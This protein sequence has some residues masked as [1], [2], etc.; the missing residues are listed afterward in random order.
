MNIYP[1]REA[2]GALI[3][4]LPLLLFSSCCLIR[5]W[6]LSTHFGC[7]TAAVTGSLTGGRLTHGLKGGR[8]LRCDRGACCRWGDPLP[9]FWCHR[10]RGSN[11]RS[12]GDTGNRTEGAWGR[13]LVVQVEERLETEQETERSGGEVKVV[14]GLDLEKKAVGGR[15]GRMRVWWW[16]GCGVWGGASGDRLEKA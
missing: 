2:P 1:G 10:S 9:A 12:W 13:D 6:I 3:P 15:E 11:H 4:V 5:P 16:P 7:G 14:F 8:L